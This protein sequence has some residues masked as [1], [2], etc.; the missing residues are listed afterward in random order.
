MFIFS[1]IFS[2]GE[3]RENMY[4][5]KISTFT[6]LPCVSHANN[7]YDYDNRPYAY[8]QRVQSA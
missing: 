7:G 6:V 4:N 2:K 8:T 5:A 3:L 1:R